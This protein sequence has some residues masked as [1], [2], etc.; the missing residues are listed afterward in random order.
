MAS[1]AE[2]APDAQES[3][4]SL[5]LERCLEVLR[6]AKNDSEQFAALLLVTKA[7]RASDVDAKTR[8]RIFNAV[9][10]T[11]PNRLLVSQETPAGCSE[12][13]Y[14]ALGLTLLACFCTDPDLAGHPQVFNKIQI[15]NE[16]IVSDCE[17]NNLPLSSMIDDAYQCLNGVLATS[18]GPTQ[19]VRNGT[20]PCLSKVYLHHSYGWHQA[21]D[22][23]ARLLTTA[24]DKCWKKCKSDLVKVLSRL[25]KD[26]QKAE[27]ASKFKLCEILPRFLPPSPLLMESWGVECLKSIYQG[28]ASILSSK[29]SESQRN[30]AFQLAGCL[31]ND[32]NA[33]WILAESRVKGSKFLALLVNLTCVEVRLSLEEPDPSYADSRQELITACYAAME[34]GLQECTREETLLMEAQKLQLI[35]ILQ[36]AC[37]AIMYYLNQVGWQRMEDPFTFASVRLL[38]A[39]LAEETSA[40]KQEVCEL[41]PFLIQYA[42]TRFKLGAAC[43]DLPRQVAKLAL[44][45]STWG[46]LWPG[47]ALRFLLPAL[48]H[49][50]A[51]ERPR[52]I[53]IAEGAPAL[54][55]E[56][57]QHLWDMFALDEQSSE[58]VSLQTA[59]GIF[60]NLVVTAPDLIRQELCF[61][62]L[63]TLLLTSLPTLLQKKEHLVLTANVATLGLMMA[64]LLS[65]S[66]DLGDAAVVKAFFRAAILFLRQAHVSEM[67]RGSE[68]LTIA[69]SGSYKAA[70]GDISELWFL[71]MQAFASCVPLLTWLPQEVL[72][73]RW[74]QDI[75]ELLGSVSPASVDLELVS[76]FQGILKEQ[77]EKSPACK[78]LILSQGGAEKSNLY[79]MAALE[80]CLSEDKPC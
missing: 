46:S 44:C 15:L 19:L 43:R 62:S 33:D 7:V 52:R 42:R 23:L 20:L 29:L 21:M 77:A 10:F 2:P 51:E 53:L 34:L 27:D 14:R 50:T 63:M 66:Q 74:I 68:K 59:C 40:L 75:L 69:V 3:A 45:S 25:S 48:C 47:D 78:E 16:T 35:A 64:R 71:G 8:R 9:G 49:L 36:E 17:V 1:S 67:N 32:Y 13:I 70:W 73:S 58:E 76:A 54:L 30:P 31:A 26:F 39:W 6:D 41:L 38:S 56:Y 57:F 79:G 22:L 61:S 72:E 65:N 11:F 80:Q 55:F 12:H 4:R 28:L 60:L 18:K 24:G 37:G 5:T